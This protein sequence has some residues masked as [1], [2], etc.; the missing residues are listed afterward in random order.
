LTSRACED[1]SLAGHLCGEHGNPDSKLRNPAGSFDSPKLCRVRVES[2]CGQVTGTY[3]EEIME[4]AVQ[5]LLPAA[6][7][8]AQIIPR[9]TEER[10]TKLLGPDYLTAPIDSR[11]DQLHRRMRVNSV[12]MSNSWKKMPGLDPYYVNMARH[13][14]QHEPPEGWDPNGP[15]EQHIGTSKEEL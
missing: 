14:S 8:C 6:E 2:V 12:G 4:V 13:I 1:K 9:C 11:L 15:D 5:S 7:Q 10:A 3:A